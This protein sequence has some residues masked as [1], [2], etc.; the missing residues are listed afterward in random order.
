MSAGIWILYA[1]GVD[2][3]RPPIG[4]DAGIWQEGPGTLLNGQSPVWMA[5]APV[6]PDQQP[7]GAWQVY[8]LTASPESRAATAT[9]CPC[10]CHT[11]R[12]SVQ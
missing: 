11:E 6:D 7:V 4:D 8:Q 10:H 12:R 1:A 9:C 3:P 2:Q 5:I